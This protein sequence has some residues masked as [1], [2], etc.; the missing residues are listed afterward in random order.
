MPRESRLD[1][2]GLLLAS[3]FYASILGQILEHLANSVTD[4]LVWK[5]YQSKNS[6]PCPSLRMHQKDF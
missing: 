5:L 1:R 2:V 6:A 3:Q 4:S